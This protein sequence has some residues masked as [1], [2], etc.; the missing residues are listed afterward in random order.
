LPLVSRLALLPAD[1][2]V[3]S[4][5]LA[6]EERGERIVFFNAAGPIYACLRSDRTG[7][8]LG[9]V[10]AIRQGLVG[11]EEMA[12]ALGLHRSTLSQDLG[13]FDRGGVEGLVAKR[14][15]PKGAHKLTPPVRRSLQRQLDRGVSITDAARSGGV[16]RRALYHAIDRGLLTLPGRSPAPAVAVAV[17]EVPAAGPSARAAEDQACEPGVAVKRTEERALASLG[18]LVEAEPEFQAA[19]AVAGAGVLLALPALLE[20]GLLEVGEEV[21]GKLRNGFFGLRSI[22]L[23]FAFM[24]LLRIKT[25][26]Q[27]TERAPGE[28]GRLLGLD[29]APEV[30]TLR[31]K[32]SEMGERKL[33]H[34]FAATF[35]ER[36]AKAQPSELGLLYVDGHVRP[37]NGRKHVLPKLHVQQRGR[38][39][40][41]TKD[42]HVGDRRAEP[43]F[44]V[45]AEATEGLLATLDGTLLPEIRELVGPRRRVTIAFDREGWSPKLF[46]KWKRQKFEVLTYRKGK[47]ATWQRRFFE[48]VEGRVDGRK[49]KYCLAERRVKLTGGLKVREIRRLAE[50]G[51]QTAVITTNEK[52]S[53]LQTAHRMFSR[54]RQENFF[55][56]MRHEFALDHLCTYEVEPADPKRMVKSPERAAVEKKLKAARAA[57]TKLLERRLELAPGKRVRVGKCMVGEDELDQLIGKREAEVEKLADALAALPKEVAIE[58]VLAPEKIVKLERERKILVDAIK[59]TAYRAESALARLVEPFH[60]RHEDEA[61]KFLKSIFLATADILPDERGRTLTIRFH[62]LANPRASR[63]LGELCS[64]ISEK[65]VCY[66][67]TD[68]RLRFD[69]LASR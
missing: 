32:L 62:G 45:T 12:Q 34:T 60:R 54:W 56:Y 10:T 4:D 27:L 51:H 61:R 50:D 37:Y 36:W 40:P 46:A 23:T 6:I 22:L 43:L 64:L 65:E 59:L 48:E 41:G 15:G 31:R 20:Q 24:A 5:D 25:P 47:Q 26:E 38:P 63:A 11:V 8:R 19:E 14:R 1:A 39:M 58:T 28:L 52:L 7:V 55:R 69:V 29:R 9:A 13:K 3:I 18:K 17:A 30:K 66:P 21:Y 67:G 16:S 42:F 49:V 68:L 57:R 53:T 35:T 2:R 44:F 33:A